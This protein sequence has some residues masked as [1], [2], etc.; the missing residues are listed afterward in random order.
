MI[1]SCAQ[2]GV[3]LKVDETKIRPEGSRLKCPKCAGIFTVYRPEAPAPP[4]QAERPS[5]APPRPAEG[6]QVQPPRPAPPPQAERPAPPT[7]PKWSLNPRTVV[8]AHDGEALTAMIS[9][10]LSAEGYRVVTAGDGVEAMVAIEREKPA[11][12]IL[13]VA[14]PRIYGFEICDRLKGSE[15]SKGIKAVLIASVYDKT[16]YKREPASLYGADDYIEKHHIED[17]LVK[18]VARLASGEA[19]PG[20]PS[21]TPPPLREER[22]FTLP[23]PPS[24]RPKRERQ[25]EEMRR[26][27]IGPPGAP[28]AADSQAVE[29]ARRFA[30]IILSDIALYNQGAV[31]EGIRTGGFRGVL[32]AELKEGRDLYNTRVSE[33]V[34]R[35]MDYF[36]DE[37]EK[38][39]EKKR[40]IM[41][42]GEMGG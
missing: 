20:Q 36:D 27:E 32:A 2:C 7:R 21:P 37:I 42:M 17:F 1:V 14:L 29:A 38:F 28:S 26:E 33:E 12:V 41:E 19:G 6:P 39:I 40:R 35:D 15:E 16:R 18:K 34:R 10:L 24:A 4:P 23:P 9:T 8:V 13:D 11:V 25:A 30:R 31:E 22:A 3:K 5:P